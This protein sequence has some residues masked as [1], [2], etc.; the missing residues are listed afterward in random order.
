M[1][2]RMPARLMLTLF[3]LLIVAGGFVYWVG[4]RTGLFEQQ[5]NAWLDSFLSAKL[6]LVI[7]VGDIGGQPWHS[8]RITDIRVDEITADA[9]RPLIRIDTVAAEYNWHDLL[10]GR[11]RAHSTTVAGVKGRG[12]VDAGGRLQLPWAFDSSATLRPRRVIELE[13]E[14]LTLRRIELAITGTDTLHLSVDRITGKLERTIDR[15]AIEAAISGLRVS[16]RQSFAVDSAHADIVGV[17]SNWFGENLYVHLDETVLTGTARLERDTSILLYAS[18]TAPHMRWNDLAR[19]VSADLVGEGSLTAELHIAGGA[20]SGRGT[21]EGDL[22]E[23]QLDGLAVSFAYQNG[24][25]VFDTLYGR[26]L[27]ADI[28][29]SGELNLTDPGLSYGVRADV[30]RLDLSQLV[31]ESPSTNI[32][33]QIDVSGAGITSD[34]LRIRI[35]TPDLY[36]RLDQLVFENAAGTLITT[37]DSLYLEPGFRARYNGID[38]VFS[39]GLS[40]SGEMA[41]AGRAVIPSVTPVFDS[42]GFPGSTG[43][44]S[45]TFALFGPLTDPSLQF[46]MV[47]DSLTYKGAAARDLRAQALLEHAFTRTT[48]PLKAF[49]A[50]LDLWGLAADSAQVIVAYGDDGLKMDPIAVYRGH[51]TLRAGVAFDP[52]SGALTVEHLHA[53]WLDRP[54]TTPWPAEFTV[55]EDTLWIHNASVLQDRG[56][57]T[58]NGWIAYG[59]RLKLQAVTADVSVAPWAGLALERDTVAGTLFADL[60]LSGRASQPEVAFRMR[61]KDAEFNGFFLGDL[62]ADG[63]LLDTAL[64]VDSLILETGLAKYTATGHVPL[65]SDSALWRPAWEKPVNG[66]VDLQGGGLRLISLFLPDVESLTGEAK[67]SADVSGTL[68]A[69]QYEGRFE[70][71]NGTV[72]IWQLVEPLTE[73]DLA[74]SLHD[75]VAIVE[76]ARASVRGREKTTGELTGSGKMVFRSLTEIDY[77]LEVTG[78]DVSASYEFAD[79]TGRFDAALR[80]R[81]YSPPTVTGDIRVR[82]AYYRDPFETSDSL[83]LVATEVEV[84]TAGWDIN[85]DVDIPKNAWTKNDEVNA[86]WSGSLRVLRQRGVWNYLGRL[87]PLRGSYDFLGR[88]FR[89]LRGEIV[90]DDIAQVDPRL[91][92]EAD[93][94]LPVPRDTQYVGGSI[95]SSQREITVGVQGRLSAPQIVPPAWLGTRNFILALNPLGSPGSETEGDW[96]QSA[97]IGATGLLTGELERLG[98]RTLG[99]ETF[100]LRPSET[101]SLD[102]LSAELSIGTYLLPDIYVYG[103]SGFD[104]T[105]GTEIG[106]EYRLRNRLT[107]QG[108]RDRRNLYQFDLNLKWEVDK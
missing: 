89:N 51:D 7:T 32:A 93:V 36:G 42:L 86:E 27:G 53:F 57:L 71:K 38:A 69:P 72:K 76:Q 73:L 84:D 9:I 33:G 106:F 55:G 16:G 41:L 3:L 82:E 4:T 94:R 29:G 59:G 30:R 99:V 96:L 11:W 108:N 61:L 102:P 18:V 103:T 26:A 15:I 49:G 58:L 6:P 12:Y 62:R 80:L 40:Y 43:R 25:L 13:I 46:D 20:V 14:E 92:L 48:G 100:E 22:F 64:A 8:L 87:E 35:V 65:S 83:S 45:G 54:F 2:L 39:G 10:A 21:V 74:L 52:K 24:L 75:T 90:F 78:T 68:G 50:G 70:L 107:L 60:Q 17:G 23:R 91:N 66:H 85:V 1:S 34:L 63:T 81:G 5:V 95:G 31:F 88:R 28:R 98:T 77:D 44:A 56:S 67:A 79:F 105:K 97:T 47:L 19:F 101:G 37:V 104:V